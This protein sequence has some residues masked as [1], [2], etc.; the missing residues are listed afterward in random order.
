MFNLTNI[1]YESLFNQVLAKEGGNAVENV[2]RISKK[3]IQPTFTKIKEEILF[4]IYG[5]N[6]DIFLLGSTGKKETSG[7]MDIR[8]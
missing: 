5:N 8:N 4:P 1:I 2:D 3:N 6:I 7:D